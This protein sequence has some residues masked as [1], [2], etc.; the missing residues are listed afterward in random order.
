MKIQFNGVQTMVRF[1]PNEDKVEVKE[2]DIFEVS[3]E[4]GNE[5]LRYSKDFKRYVG[6][7][8]ES[9]VDKGAVKVGQTSDG[10][11]KDGDDA[12]KPEGKN[13]KKADKKPAKK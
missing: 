11:D 10:K 3:D 4:R 6:A 13:E 7:V 1:A 2:G 8:D 9:K 5:L 12:G